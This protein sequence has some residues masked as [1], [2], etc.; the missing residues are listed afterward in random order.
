PDALL[1][2]GRLLERAGEHTRAAEMYRAMQ[3]AYSFNETAPDALFA[4]GVNAYR[5]NDISEAL[6]AWRVL[7]DTYSVANFYPA[8]LLWQGKLALTQGK[9]EA[10]QGLLDQAAQAK[11]LDY[12]G[13]RAAE[14][15][16]NRPILQSLPF[17]LDFDSVA[18]RAAAEA[19][20]A[21]WTGRQNASRIGSLPPSILDDGRLQRG[22][23]LWRLGWAAQAKD[24]FESLRA[25]VKDDPIALY[26]LSLYWRDLGLY[27]SSLLAAA[28]LIAISPAKDARDAPAFIARLAYPTYYADLVISAAE[29]H[30]LDPLLLFALIRQESQFEH[31]A[32]SSANAHGLMQV[33]PATG[34][35]IA[36]ALGWPNY[37]ASE[38]YKPYV[39]VT[40]GSYYLAR[41]RDY[42]EGDLYAALAAYNGG[43]GNS[44]RWR[45]L[46]QAD[47]DLFLE[48]IALNETHTYL[49]R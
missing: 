15:R 21:D 5:A 31:I 46:A 6:D 11:P 14:L 7:S 1:R 12:Y 44:A 4:A 36:T 23:E 27:R 34:Q 32:T 8:A 38:L 48:T 43:P 2:A 28:R 40:F 42:L 24:E 16:D 20:L 13:I 29:A 3:A 41:Q 9:V 49:M 45:D 10:A 17:R 22:A 47:P 30:G 18:D 26:A 25:A 19:W 39:S 33:I 37:N 35:E